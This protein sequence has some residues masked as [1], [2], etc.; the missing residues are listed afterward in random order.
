MSVTIDGAARF[1]ATLQAAAAD[2]R[3]L[4]DAHEDAVGQGACHGID[5]GI[6]ACDLGGGRVP[7]GQKLIAFGGDLGVLSCHQ[8]GG[9][10]AQGPRAERNSHSEREEDRNDRY[11]VVA[12]TNQRR[13]LRIGCRATE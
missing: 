13:L 2:L 4:S 12:E 7:I 1:S 5:D 10:I 3:D 11:Q 8:I 9:A 6:A